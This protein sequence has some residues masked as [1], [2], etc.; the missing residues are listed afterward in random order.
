MNHSDTETQRIPL[1]LC[2][3]VSLWLMPSACNKGPSTQAREA[4]EV[5]IPRGAGGIGFLPL[6]VMEKYSLIE[7]QAQD[8]GIPNL[9]V[10]WID[11]GGPVV[12]NDSLLSGAVDFIA[13]GPPA[14]IVLWDR[15]RDSAKVKGVAAMSSLPMYLN[16][17][18]DHLKKLDDITDRDKIA[19]TAVKVSIP[20][21]IIPIYTRD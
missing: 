19:V 1:F 13:A 18:A 4:T 7:R 14:F 15:T 20:S 9:H 12:M 10:Q 5:R 2:V 3:F 17:R 8:A 21:I 6:L 16:A 11:L